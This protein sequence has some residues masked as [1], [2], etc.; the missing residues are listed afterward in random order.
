MSV[1]SIT[2]SVKLEILIRLRLVYLKET[3]N[4]W[5]I[6]WKYNYSKTSHALK[7]CF[8]ALEK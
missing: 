7:I 5:V 4:P 6:S 2:P 3:R 8:I 1:M